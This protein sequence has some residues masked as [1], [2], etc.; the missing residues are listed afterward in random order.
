MTLSQMRAGEHY[1]W[2]DLM[3]IATCTSKIVNA[4]HIVHATPS[5]H[6]GIQ[7]KCYVEQLVQF[8]DMPPRHEQNLRG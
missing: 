2:T 8:E 6:L 7:L 5:R 4:L 1:T 3:P